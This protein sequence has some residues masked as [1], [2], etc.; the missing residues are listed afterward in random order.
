[1]SP[2]HS[3]SPDM[4]APDCLRPVCWGWPVP[5]AVLERVEQ[6]IIRQEDPDNHLLLILSDW[7][8]GRCAACGTACDSL[9]LD[10]D[11]YTALVRGYLC[12]SCNVAEGQQGNG[13]WRA[14]RRC[15]ASV[16]LRIVVQYSSG[17]GGAAVPVTPD[18]RDY[19]QRRAIEAG[20]AVQVGKIIRQ[21]AAGVRSAPR[22]NV[23]RQV[24]LADLAAAQEADRELD[25]DLQCRHTAGEAGGYE[26]ARK[27][28]RTRARKVR[29]AYLAAHPD[30][31][32]ALDPAALW[33]AASA[34]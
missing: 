13:R 33:E 9:V 23:G 5:A 12:P 21:Q 16:L 31:P 34:V 10:H 6:V 32:P 24:V 15:P 29:Q 3:R 20:K 17:W 11:H 27:V 25:R 30:Y 8:R 7:Q 4:T 14:W 18:E 19:A 1:M 28:W 22:K 26:R 2:T